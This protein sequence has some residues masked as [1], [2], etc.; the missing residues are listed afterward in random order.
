VVVLWNG[1]PYYYVTSLQGDV[2][3]ILDNTGEL[4]VSY[5]YDAWGNILATGGSLAPTLG[6]YN[7]LRYRGYVYDHETGLYYLQSRYYNPQWGRFLNAD[8]LVSTGQGNLGNNMFAYCLNNPVAYQ[9]SAGTIACTCM[10][11]G[12]LFSEMY[13]GACTGGG[14][15]GSGGYAAPYA[16]Q[17]YLSIQK[18]LKLAKKFITNES[19][20]AT[21]EYLDKYG[22]AFYKGV[23]VFLANIGENGGGFSY[24]V[25]VL[26]DAYLTRSD[27]IDVLKHEYG[28]RVHMDQIGLVNYTFTTAIPSLIGAGFDV[29]KKLGISYYDLP[30]EH[31][32]DVLG[33]VYRD[34]YSPWACDAASAFWL[35]TMIISRA[36]GGV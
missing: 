31:T 24:G 9:D 6:A 36:T 18:M 8:T 23:P 10:D 30:W 20:E 27:R 14:G 34:E 25:I 21:F 13:F 3:L 19:E 22:F 7:P 15:G 17:T 2:V 1:T 32:A 33:G 28:H 4:V 29:H 12:L 5:D 26:D 11:D 35:Y 16:A